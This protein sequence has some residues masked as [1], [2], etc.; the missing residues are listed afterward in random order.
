[1]PRISTK[2]TGTETVKAKKT[3]ATKVNTEVKVR[4]PR[5]K[6]VKADAKTFTDDGMFFE[7]KCIVFRIPNDNGGTNILKEFAGPVTI[8]KNKIGK[9]TKMADGNWAEITDIIT[10][11]QHLT[12]VIN[13]IA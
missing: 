12:F 4:K 8:G 3:T 9:M 5:V 11:E 7:A 13:P 6:K 10:N 1:M 2:K